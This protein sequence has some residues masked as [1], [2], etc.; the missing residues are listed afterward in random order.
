MP[1]PQWPTWLQWAQM[2]SVLL[3]VTE[4]TGTLLL[5]GMKPDEK[6]VTFVMVVSIVSQGEA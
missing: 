5:T 1:F 4:K 2:G 3:T 6:P